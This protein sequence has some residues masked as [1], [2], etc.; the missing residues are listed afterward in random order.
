[1]T[2]V[3]L[4]NLL[5][6]IAPFLFYALYILIEKKPETK[7][8]FWRLIPLRKLLVAGFCLMVIFYITQ[9]RFTGQKDGIYHPATV[10]D[11]KVIPGYIEPIEKPEKQPAEKSEN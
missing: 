3:I 1:M 10:R 11:G 6:I 8:E 2:R 4:I 7:D 5:A 9:I